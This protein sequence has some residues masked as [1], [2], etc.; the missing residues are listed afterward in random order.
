MSLEQTR[1]ASWRGVMLS[2]RSAEET[3]GAARG[4]VLASNNGES[5]EESLFR[6]ESLVRQF[7][8]YQSPAYGFRPATIRLDGQR[9][10]GFRREELGAEGGAV[11]G[12]HQETSDAVMVRIESMLPTV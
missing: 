1:N 9:S 4:E 2:D 12:T 3:A 8:S 7:G 5:S 10:V 11:A 6:H